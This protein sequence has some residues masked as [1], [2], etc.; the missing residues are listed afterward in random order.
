[1]RFYVV[2]KGMWYYSIYLHIWP[3][4]EK[5]ADLVYRVYTGIQFSSLAC[6]HFFFYLSLAPT[7]RLVVCTM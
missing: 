3:E 7:S 2:C 1:M 6:S 4:L 5:L